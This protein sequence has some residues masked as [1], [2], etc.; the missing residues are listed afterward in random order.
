MTEAEQTLNTPVLLSEEERHRL[1]E[2]A[3]IGLYRWY[4]SRSQ[5]KRNW[6]ADS[7]VNWREM[8]ADHSE[9]VALLIEG[10]FAVEQFAPDYTSEILR[11]VRRS[12]GRSHF[13]MRWG[14]EEE[15]H[16][17]TWENALLFSKSRSPRYI[18]EYKKELRNN[19]WTL[20]WDDPLHMMV[21]TVFQE[22]ATQVNYLNFA[23]LSRG[24]AA[25]P[26]YDTEADP[27]LER[28][29]TI[30]ATDEA[31]HYYFFLECARLYLYYF[32]EETLQAILDVVTHFAMPAQDI[33]PNWPVIA[34]TIYKTGVY[35]P[36]E[37]QRNVIVPV[38]KNLTVEGKKALEAGL[39]RSREIPNRDGVFRTSAFWETFD[40]SAA[41]GNVKNVFEKI[42]EYEVLIGRDAVDPTLYVPN[43][44]WPGRNA[45]PLGE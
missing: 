41:E 40:A 30:L 16:A 4:V 37:F 28:A 26:G 9:D 35:G 13:Q 21:Y 10:F 14:A 17:N 38:M 36:R 44:D 19:T 11:L 2:R 33:I 8:R 23:Q 31:A 20:P 27:I 5:V 42:H 18:D 32:P 15:R 43:P 39:K 29:C 22:R 12:H 3:F 34:E 25:K 24:Q 45:P 6:N 1:L 7:F